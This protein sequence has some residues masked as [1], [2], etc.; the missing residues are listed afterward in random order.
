MLVLTNEKNRPIDTKYPFVFRKDFLG[1]CQHSNLEYLLISDE[2]NEVYLP[3]VIS[4]SKFIKILTILHPPLKNGKSIS[5]EEEEMFFNEL[6]YFVK[7]KKFADRIKYPMHLG[8]FKS[9]PANASS[10]SFGLIEADLS[11]ELDELFMKFKKNYRNEIRKSIKEG[12]EIK[13]GEDQ[14]EPFYKVYQE[15]MKRN[16]LFLESE[17]ALDSFKNGMND[18]SGTICAVAYYK[19]EVLG[20]ALVPYSNYGGFYL[21]GGSSEKQKIVGGL[22]LMH[23]EIMKV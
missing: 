22:K 1:Y 18:N 23:W 19:G 6:I 11:Q 8:V 14:F 16:D 10:I 4:K 5:Y 13:F 3:I 21:Y 15:T 2:N 9:A 12:V 17:G 7:K 20:G